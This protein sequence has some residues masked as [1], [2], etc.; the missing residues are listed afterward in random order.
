MSLSSSTLKGGGG[1]G[2]AA[3][4]GGTAIPQPHGT[5]SVGVSTKFAHEDHVHAMPSAAQVNSLNLPLAWNA[6]TNVPLLTSSVPP[7]SNNCYRV[8]VAGTTTLDGV[9]TWGIDDLLY[10]DGSVWVKVAA[11]SG[12]V[13]HLTNYA[14]E[15]AVTTIT[16]S[17]T[18]KT[19]SLGILPTGTRVRFSFSVLGGN[20]TGD[21]ATATLRLGGVTIATPTCTQYGTN[22]SVVGEIV[23]TSLTSQVTSWYVTGPTLASG[24]FVANA[25]TAV[26]VDLTITL[27]VSATTRALGASLTA[28][29]VEIYQP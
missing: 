22:F 11:T 20:Y 7:A 6:S 4:Q 24:M 19:L 5:A 12:G 9:S 10:F 3:A 15:A 28:L 13:Q 14:T 18:L 17:P 25:N 2:G 1:G 21:T 27:K 23:C 8:T 26:P 16:E 29:D